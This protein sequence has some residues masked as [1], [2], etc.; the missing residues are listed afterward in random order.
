MLFAPYSN[1]A[2]SMIDS[3]RQGIN[4]RVIWLFHLLFC[5]TSLPTITFSQITLIEDRIRSG[6]ISTVDIVISSHPRLWTK[7]AWD[8]DHNNVGSF[9]WRII[10]GEEQPWPWLEDPANDQEKQEFSYVTGEDDED[11]YGADNMYQN[12]DH[13][14]A[15]RVLEPII[16]GKAQK[17]NWGAIYHGSYQATYDLDHTANEYFSDARGKLLNLVQ[18]ATEYEYPF[19]VALF[20][21]VAYDWL[22]NETDTNGNPVLSESDKATIQNRLIVHGDYLFSNASGSGSAFKAS[23]TDHFYFAM[24]GMALYE[25]SRVNDPTYSAI[26]AKA[27]TYL[28]EFDREVIGRILPIWNEQGGDGG[29]PG[30]LTRLDAP[31]WLGGA[32]ESD[33]NVGILMMTPVFFAH[34]T[35]TGSNFEESLFNTGM[36]RNFAEFQLHMITPSILAEY[37]GANYYDIGGSNTEGARSPW[38]APM[39][40]YSRRRFSSNA[41]QKNIG[42]LGAWI[43]TNFNKTYTDFGSWDMLEQLLF[44]DKWVNPRDP[45]AVG[46]PVTRHFQ[47]LG[48]LFMRSGFSSENDLAALFICQRY[49]WSHLDPYAQN[50]FTLEYGGKLVEGYNNTIFI[51][52]DGQRTI[53]QFPT[54]SDGVSAYAP[55]TLYDVGPGISHFESNSEYDYVFGDATRAYDSTEVEKFTR[56]LV[57]LK[58]DVFIIFDRIVTTS[59]EITKSWVINPGRQPEELAADL[60]R[61]T[62]GN[63]AL[64]IKRMLPADVNITSQTANKFEVA[65]VVHHSIEYFL[66]V[67]QASEAGLETT[68]PMVIA[69]DALY[70]ENQ[71]SVGVIVG[72]YKVSFSKSGSPNISVSEYSQIIKVDVMVSHRFNLFQNYPNPFNPLTKIGYFIPHS[73]Y[74]NLT[75]YDIS[76]QQV[77]TLVQEWESAGKKWTLWDGRDQF[78]KKVASGVYI[79]RLAAKGSILTKKMHL[80]H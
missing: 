69:D 75:I 39:R 4:K 22:V 29:W 50:S 68:D 57:Y 46:F 52:G 6:E 19:V 70:Y 65:P 37:D 38:I 16:A 66:N 59:P 74:V 63:G 61:V 45:E 72:S 67:L 15:R 54:I 48:W 79:Y 20:A 41:E 1:R 49:H 76:G 73:S 24:I 10:H 55:S 60:Y 33:D 56:Q 78:G 35:A 53:T 27:K 32:Y 77:R 47:K 43:R 21:S 30:G 18:E 40:A 3:I 80:L 11:S 51:N 14:F 7:G 8:W 25:P 28:D 42:E 2:G 58:P 71:D 26:N 12:Y 9:A 62:N 34:Y 31:F 17:L 13:D 64:W 44:E 23:D 5:V 36:L